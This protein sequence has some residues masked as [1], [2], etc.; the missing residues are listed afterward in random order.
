[1][2]HILGTGYCSLYLGTYAFNYLR[3]YVAHYKYP[4]VTFRLAQ[5]IPCHCWEFLFPLL[6]GFVLHK[7]ELLTFRH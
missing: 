2:I 4:W 5:T 3:R 1:M 6:Y 7:A